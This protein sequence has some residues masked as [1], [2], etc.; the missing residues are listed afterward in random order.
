[1][2]FVKRIQKQFMFLISLHPSFLY[3][4]FGR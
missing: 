4:L 3:K 2:Y 1:M